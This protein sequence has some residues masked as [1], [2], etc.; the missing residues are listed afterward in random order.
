MEQDYCIN[1]IVAQRETKQSKSAEEIPVLG[2]LQVSKR[3]ML[4]YCYRVH[5]IYFFEKYSVVMIRPDASQLI[6]YYRL[7]LK[8]F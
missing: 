7:S 6:Y 4:G 5:V 2:T 1:Q 3:T 8:V